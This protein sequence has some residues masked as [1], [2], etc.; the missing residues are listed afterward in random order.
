MESFPPEYDN[1]LLIS[2]LP[3]L[4]RYLLGF[5]FSFG[6]FQDYYNSLPLFASN[7]SGV[8]IIGTSAS[9]I[10]YLGAPF[11]FFALQAWPRFRRLCSLLGLIIITIAL[12]GSSFSTAVWHL[13]V[14][15]GVLYAIGGSLLYAPAILYLDEWF[16]ARKGFAYGVMWAGTGTSGVIVPFIMSWGLSAYGFRTM[17]RAWAITLIVLSTPLIYYVKPRIPF[18]P[19]TASHPRRISFEF[20]QTPT[21]WILQAGNIVE[22]LGFFI[23]NFYLPQYARSLNLTPISGSLILALFNLT[24]VLGQVGFG[25][26]ID[27]ME[28]T[29]VILISSIGTTISVFI[30]WG[31]GISLPLLCVFALLY[32]I[33]GGGFTST[34]TGMIRAV[35]RR[36][37]SAETGMVFSLLAAGRGIG[38]VVS[39]PV[40]ES[41]L[42]GLPWKDGAA[43]GYGTGYGGLIV[44][45]GVTALCGGLSFVGKRAK[46]I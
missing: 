15:Q 14:T 20:L 30:F 36:T 44:F 32:G 42:N 40:G 34:Y 19:L 27:K 41:L 35:Q 25:I 46:M 39:G 43:L 10:M 28:V 31:L 12:I 22:G 5:P 7:N 16:I 26:L 29:S 6:V 3:R 9:G 4:T 18:N 21:F 2:F 13:I 17:L 38:A 45:T 1:N 33:F 8:A 23:P 37:P 24:S 11:V